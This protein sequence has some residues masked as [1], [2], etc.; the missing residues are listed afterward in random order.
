MSNPIFYT[1]A[2]VSERLE[3]P[4]DTVRRIVR[5]E[6]AAMVP[7][8]QRFVPGGRVDGKVL[9]IYADIFEAVVSAKAVTRTHPGALSLVHTRKQAA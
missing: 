4:E 5:K 1:S 3:L 6:A 2:Q 9:R 8:D 7:D